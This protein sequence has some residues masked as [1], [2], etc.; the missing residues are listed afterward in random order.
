MKSNI[1]KITSLILIMFLLFTFSCNN[2]KENSSETYSVIYNLMGGKLEDGAEEYKITV[3]HG[4]KIENIIPKKEGYAFDGWTTRLTGIL[5]PDYNFNNEITEN[6]VLYAVWRRPKINFELNDGYFTQYNNYNE[7]VDD[8][9][10]AFNAANNTDIEVWNFFDRTYRIGLTFFR[11]ETYREKWAPLLDYINVSG[12]YTSN[13]EQILKGGYEYNDSERSKIEAPIR[14]E[15]ECLLKKE[16]GNRADINT[17]TQ[18]YRLP[19][20]QEQIIHYFKTDSVNFYNSS[21]DFQLPIP[22]K[23]GYN[24]LGWYNNENFNGEAITYIS[25]GTTDNLT[26]YAKWESK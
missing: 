23:L 1:T 2:D 12:K 11:N 16:Q 6:T 13:I 5:T 4:D 20:I 24:F 18:N 19:E 7:V 21:S 22:H 26:F 25:Q 15:I 3:K 8:F 9:L 10:A 14:Y 17:E